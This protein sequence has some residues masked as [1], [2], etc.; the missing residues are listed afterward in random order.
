L[1]SSATSSKNGRDFDQGHRAD[2]QNFSSR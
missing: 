2:A 1:R